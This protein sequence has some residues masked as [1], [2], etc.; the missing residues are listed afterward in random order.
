MKNYYEILEVSNTASLDIIKKVFKIQ[1]KKYHPDVTN[2]DKKAYAEEKVKELNEAYNILSDEVKR[3]EYDILL[4]NY[5]EQNNFSQKEQILTEQIDYL[6]AQLAKKDQIIDHFLGGLDLSEYE[7]LNPQNHNKFKDENDIYTSKT[8]EEINN[9]YD[10]YSSY[11]Y[12]EDPKNLLEKI[13]NFFNPNRPY[14]SLSEHYMHILLVYIIK[15]LVF[16][17]FLSLLF[18]GISIM[19]QTNV[20]KIIFEVFFH[21]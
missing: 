14:N 11:E 20:F 17:L 9:L 10:Q 21:S 7:E 12:H 2:D 16:L 18:A 1:I 15:I 19:T 5:M 4:K 3:K 8:N 6:K 13:Q